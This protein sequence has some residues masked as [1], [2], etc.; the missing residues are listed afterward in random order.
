ML[1]CL[2]RERADQKASGFLEVTIYCGHY[3]LVQNKIGDILYFPRWDFRVRRVSWS[4]YKCFILNNDESMMGEILWESFCLQIVV[5]PT[6]HS[7]RVLSKWAGFAHQECN[8]Q[9]I[10]YLNKNRTE[11]S[12]EQGTAQPSG[13]TCGRVTR[14]G[15]GEALQDTTQWSRSGWG[16]DSFHIQSSLINAVFS[17]VYAVLCYVPSGTS[18][19][20]HFTH[21]PPPTSPALHNCNNQ[22]V[23]TDYALSGRPVT[24]DVK[25]SSPGAL[26]K[27]GCLRLNQ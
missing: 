8:T 22:M 26:A 24:S 16:L 19:C 15:W 18:R 5:A 23:Y 12:T 25:G 14:E 11:A 21:R 9:Y 1:V 2:E 27:T 17:A 3:L 7:D 10:R 13:D 4:R 20:T 6:C